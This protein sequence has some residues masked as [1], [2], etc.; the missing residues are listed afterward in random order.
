MQ[1]TAASKSRS[2]DDPD[3][4]AEVEKQRNDRRRNLVIMVQRF[5]AD[6]GYSEAVEKLA[7]ASGVSLEEYDVGDNIDLLMVVQEFEDFYEMKFGKRP[8]LVR[9]TQ[10]GKAPGKPSKA[11]ARLPQLSRG[12]I[13]VSEDGVK[14]K[15]VKESRA[16]A[17]APAG[18]SSRGKG[19]ETDLE[20]NHFVRRI[21]K[22]VPD[23]GNNPE[24]RELAGQITRDIYMECP[25]VY[26]EDVACQDATKHLL[27]EAVVMPLRYPQ[28]FTGLLSPWKGVLLYGPPGNGK[29]MLAKAVAT[30]CETTFFN[31]SASSVVS[32]WRGDSEKLIRVLFELARHH[33]PSTVFL[34]ELDSVMMSRDG[35]GEHEASR[36]MKTELLIQMDGLA[37]SESMVFVL[38]ASN[39]PWDLDHAALRR[40]E[41]R[42]LVA[43]PDA[44]ARAQIFSLQMQQM[45]GGCEVSSEQLAAQTEGFSG[46]DVVL[47]AKEAAMRPLRRLMLRIE[48]NAVGPDEP[49]STGPI[50]A[51]DV[52]EASPSL[53]PE[54]Y[55]MLIIMH[56]HEHTV[57]SLK[58]TDV[59]AYSQ[60]AMVS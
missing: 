52:T 34:D 44:Q 1:A 57:T 5:M 4:R 53:V 31:I 32:K 6:H 58:S 20:E 30:E 39:V 7:T 33:A 16:S 15:E 11:G 37:K 56:G 47:L 48:Q 17:G 25:N 24:L 41:K 35:G 9:K 3:R 19:D 45:P 36:R 12:G 49:L 18:N 38:G 51:E 60:L 40:F 43:M 42:I 2:R 55:R 8:R 14:S 26:F 28:L 13:D 23:F 46:S 54:Q 59:A 27:K 21:L 22:P 10:G 50:T 29:T